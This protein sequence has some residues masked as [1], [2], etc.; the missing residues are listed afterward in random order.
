MWHFSG[1]E[2]KDI[3]LEMK[4]ASAKVVATRIAQL[5]KKLQKLNPIDF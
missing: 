1:K 5:I 3:A 2:N 4:Y